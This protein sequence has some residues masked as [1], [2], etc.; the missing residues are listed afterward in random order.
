[1]PFQPGGAAHFPKETYTQCPLKARCTTSQQGRSVSI[2]PDEAL[3]IE[4]RERRQTSLGRAK[5]RER[6]A[7]LIFI[8]L[9][10]KNDYA[11]LQ[12]V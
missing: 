5:L 7:P 12:N 8:S 2:H 4:L 9:S 11:V 1:M 3:L 10:T 6:Y